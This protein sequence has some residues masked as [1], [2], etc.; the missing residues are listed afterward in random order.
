MEKEFTISRKKQF[1]F[2]INVQ[3]FALTFPNF[4]M[5]VIE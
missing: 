3:N 2:A 1:F 5:N 4:Y